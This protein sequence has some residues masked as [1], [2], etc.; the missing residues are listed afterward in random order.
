MAATVQSQAIEGVN[1]GIGSAQQLMN[2]YVQLVHLKEIWQDVNVGQTI[3]AMSTIKLNADGSLGAAD[4][5]PNAGNPID[6]NKYPT[7]SR[8]LSS[9]Q[10][11]QMKT[12]LDGIVDYIEG[13]AVSAQPG[14][15]AILN[16]AIG[17]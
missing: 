7:L 9:T 2:L 12:I 4:T 3:S 13:R 1:G 17:G 5:T 14:A 6:T 10:I 11:A 8:A 15:R 16:T